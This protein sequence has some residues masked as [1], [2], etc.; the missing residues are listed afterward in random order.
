[1]TSR[2]DVV[3][4]D[5]PYSDGGSKVRPALVVQND[6]DNARLAKTVIALITGNLRPAGDPSHF[7]VDPAAPDG[8]GSGL[9]GPSPVSCNNKGR[10]LLEASLHACP[11][12]PRRTFTP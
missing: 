5:F 2:G 7:L 12:H 9:R 6:R 3:V 8:A 11:S 4:V 10:L 1:M